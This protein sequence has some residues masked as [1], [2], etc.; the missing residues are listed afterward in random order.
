MAKVTP[1][2]VVVVIV[3]IVAVGLRL[4]VTVNTDPVQFPDIGVTIYVAVTAELVVLMT[5]P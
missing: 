3:E 1:L 2:Q 5:V 4:T